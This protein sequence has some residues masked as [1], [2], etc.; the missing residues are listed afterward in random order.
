AVPAE[1]GLILLLFFIGLDFSLDTLVYNWKRTVSS[2]LAD[3]ALS[4]PAGV[5]FGLL[6]GAG[7]VNSFY[8]G[9]IVYVTSS[10]IVTKA[11]VENRLTA[12]P[13]SEVI[14][15]VAVFQDIIIALFLAVFTGIGEDASLSGSFAALAKAVLFFFIFGLVTRFGVRHIN[16]VFS[17]ESSELFVMLGLGFI[18]TV[19]WSASMF[20][21]SYAVGAFLAGTLLS[22]TE[23]KNRIEE[24]LIP[25]KD[26]FAAVFFLH[27]GMSIG[28]KETLPVLGPALAIIAA[29][30]VTKMAA[31]KII[32]MVEKLSDR[33]SLGVG[34]GLLARGEFSIIAASLLVPGE[35]DG[36]TVAALKAV[37]A[38]FVLATGIMGAVAMKEYPKIYMYV[39]TRRGPARP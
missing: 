23:H 5:A 31:G 22:R 39:R 24:G 37:A 21:I 12:M 25:V 36:G 18:I 14:L 29:G 3:F 35:G 10:A 15:R 4:F 30:F 13:E 2:G 20:G 1:I 11:M 7:L 19:S 26:L 8:M 17:V 34:V 16:R 32:G 9:A 33:A 27:F 28:L 6:M 38:V